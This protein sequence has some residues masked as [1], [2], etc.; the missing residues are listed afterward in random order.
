MF[1]MP[2]PIAMKTSSVICIPSNGGCNRPVQRFRGSGFPAGGDWHLAAAEGCP[3]LQLSSA[4][5]LLTS[6]F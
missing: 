6:V 4:L 1:W 5:C 2:K 3:A